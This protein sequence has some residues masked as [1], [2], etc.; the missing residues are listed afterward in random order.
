[1]K[2]VDSVEKWILKI[3]DLYLHYTET[4]FRIQ[5]ENTNFWKRIVWKR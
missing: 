2:V 3:L 1:M 4:P 5:L